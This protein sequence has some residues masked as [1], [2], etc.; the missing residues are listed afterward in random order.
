MS[1]YACVDPESLR[2]PNPPPP[3]EPTSRSLSNFPADHSGLEKDLRQLQGLQRRVLNQQEDITQGRINVR[4]QIQGVSVTTKARLNDVDWS[5]NEQ[6]GEIQH[7]K[8]GLETLETK[9]A[10]LTD[11]VQ[12]LETMYE[13]FKKLN[14]NF[15]S[16]EIRFGDF[17]T[18]RQ[19][20][21]ERRT[22]A[23]I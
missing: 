3:Y 20:N 9:V 5:L 15:R 17:E 8:D 19:S 6:D 18:C 4:S 12:E 10:A 23:G 22:Q 1:H 21:E 13:Q 2:L 11:R 14:D 16:L 7:A